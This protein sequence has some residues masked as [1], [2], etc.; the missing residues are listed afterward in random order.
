[1]DFHIFITCRDFSELE[2]LGGLLEYV[3]LSRNTVNRNWS[4]M[5]WG[6]LVEIFFPIPN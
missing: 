1:M 2:S 4:V 3:H 5:L 6:I